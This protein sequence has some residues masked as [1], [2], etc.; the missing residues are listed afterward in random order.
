MWKALLTVAGLCKISP[1][2]KPTCERNFL[3]SLAAAHFS[4]EYSKRGHE[5]SKR[6]RTE[7]A[8]VVNSQPSR[9]AYFLST[10][11]E[12]PELRHGFFYG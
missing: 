2:S 6:R 11:L 12:Y 9:G 1:T 8:P 3:L 10:R 4:E 7:N 5:F